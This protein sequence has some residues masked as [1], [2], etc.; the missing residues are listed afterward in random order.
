MSILSKPFALAALEKALKT[1][2]QAAILAI[3]GTGMAAT[4]DAQVNAFTVDWVAVGGFALGGFVLSVLFSVASNRLGK[5]EGPSL[6]DEA[7]I[8]PEE[9][10]EYE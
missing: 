4:Q 6:T 3:I 1:A 10:A 5:W 8:T 2:A 9:A 7:I